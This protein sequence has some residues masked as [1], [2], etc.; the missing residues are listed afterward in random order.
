LAANS[1]NNQVANYLKSNKDSFDADEEAF[2]LDQATEED[3]FLETHS[4]LENIYNEIE[5]LSNN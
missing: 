3:K 2:N 5:V 1:K 4:S